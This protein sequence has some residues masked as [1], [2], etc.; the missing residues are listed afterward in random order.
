MRKEA[1][2]AISLAPGPVSQSGSEPAPAR[3]VVGMEA[4]A[5]TR[6]ETMMTAKP[7]RLRTW[8]RS[9]PP[10]C[11]VARPNMARMPL[12]R[13]PMRLRAEYRR[14]PVARTEPGLIAESRVS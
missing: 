5:V 7:R 13:A 4:A 9:G 14:T 8:A 2:R 6:T 3:A 11:A 1:S 12:A 10:G